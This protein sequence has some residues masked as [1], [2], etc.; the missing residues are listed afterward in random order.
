MKKS[1]A[2]LMALMLIVVSIAGCS[3]GTDNGGAEEVKAV[4]LKMNLTTNENST[5]FLGAT[6][7]KEIVEEKTNGKYLVDIFPSEQLSG[8]NQVKGLEMVQTSTTDLDIHS[9]IIY[10]IMDPKFTVVNMPWMI[11]TYEEA[12]AAMAGE[13][14]AA[15]FELAKE[16]GVVPLAFGESGYR[17]ITNSVRPITSP[18]DLNG[19]KL[20]VPGIKMFVDLFGVLGADP[21]TMD[22]AEVFTSLQQ[23]TI[24]GQENPLDIIKSSKLEEVQEY[25]SLWNYVYDALLMS[26][27]EDTWAMLTDEEKVIFQDA[28]TEAMNYQK[29]QNRLKDQ[30][31]LAYLQENMDV[32]EMTAAE[33]AVFKDMAKPVYESYEEIIGL[34]LMELFGYEK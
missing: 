21:T 31:N 22:F 2:L 28:A 1:L 20:R 16:N 9:T 12:D 26:A 6:K 32:H 34:E 5:W 33:V 3:S 8:G 19:V 23:G 11:P 14:G 17:Q 4:H 10:T 7:F 27:S 25:L 15:I 24:D 29:E 30:D 13:G 18:A